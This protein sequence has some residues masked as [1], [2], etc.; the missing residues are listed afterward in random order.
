MTCYFLQWQTYVRSDTCTSGQHEWI[1]PLG[2]LT[3]HVI[4]Q[5]YSKL[6]VED[7]TEGVSAVEVEDKK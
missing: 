3:P 1:S 2:L 4:P 6:S 7:L 5:M